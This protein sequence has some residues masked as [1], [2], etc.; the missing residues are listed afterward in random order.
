MIT[1]EILDDDIKF[2]NLGKEPV[3]IGMILRLLTTNAPVQCHFH[4]FEYQNEWTIPYFD[5][6]G[7]GIITV[8][9]AESS[10]E[11]FRVM[12]PREFSKKS[13][14]KNVIAIGLNKTGTTSLNRDLVNLGYNLFPE[15]IGHQYLFPDVYRGDFHSTIS[16]IENPRYNL[17]Q[18]LPTSLPNVYKKIK[19]LSGGEKSRVVLACILANPV[20]L[21]ILDEPTNH[22][23]IKSREVLL[24]NLQNFDGT[25]LIVSHD[26]HFLKAVSNRV[27]EVDHG[28]MN[29]FEGNYDYYLSK[30]RQSL[31]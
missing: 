21:L 2:I 15:L 25:I 14:G 29:V 16:S 26:R 31:N 28:R 10:R 19:V 5:Y 6:T 13:K 9:E 12:I 3:R 8:H 1:Y 20:N 7:C 11:I 27:F 24:K 23:D 4:N 22:L 18:D 17:H 30:K